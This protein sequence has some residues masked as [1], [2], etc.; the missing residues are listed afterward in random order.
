MEKPKLRLRPE[1]AEKRRSEQHA[2]QHFCNHL[3][4]AETHRDGANEPTE[5]ED[6]GELEK[7]LNGEMQIVHWI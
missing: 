1:Q 2:S 6:D 3:R 7:K 4:L 5:K